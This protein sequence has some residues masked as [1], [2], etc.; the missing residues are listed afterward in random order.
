MGWMWARMAAAAAAGDTPYHRA[1]RPVADFF[2]QRMLSQA[3]GLAL[4]ISSGEASIMALPAD[5]F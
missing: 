5:A 1:K 2:A 4:S 3:Q